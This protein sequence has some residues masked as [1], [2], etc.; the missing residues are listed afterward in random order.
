MHHRDFV[1]FR[2]ADTVSLAGTH[3]T[4]PAL[5]AVAGATLLSRVK[6]RST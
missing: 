3:V 1:R 6:C 2:A 4:T 5:R